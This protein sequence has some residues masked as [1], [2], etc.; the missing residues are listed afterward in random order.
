MSKKQWLEEECMFTYCTNCDMC[1]YVVFDDN[2]S[3]KCE[4][5]MYER[6]ISS[7]EL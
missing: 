5:E 4:K 2:G 3:R 7:E 6:C 1:P